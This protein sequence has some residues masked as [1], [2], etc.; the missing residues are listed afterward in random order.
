MSGR[1][2]KSNI[3]IKKYIDKLSNQPFAGYRYIFAVLANKQARNPE[4]YRP[5][6]GSLDKVRVVAFDT[7]VL[8]KKW[9]ESFQP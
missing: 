1:R 9:L 2:I 3:K 4:R 6:L 8:S 5:C 7:E